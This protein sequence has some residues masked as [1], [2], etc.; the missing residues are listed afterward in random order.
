MRAGHLLRRRA[1]HRAQ[2]LAAGAAPAPRWPAPTWRREVTTA[3]AVH[4]P[5]RRASGGSRV[6]ALDLGIKANTPRMLAA[7][8][9]ETHVLPATAT[10][11]ELL[12]RRARRG[13]PLQRPG[14]PGHR[15]PRRG[16]DRARCCAAGC[17]C[18]ASAS[19]T[20]SS[21]ARSGFGTYKLPLRAPR[22]QRAGHRPHHRHGRDHRAEPRLRGRRAARRA[23]RLPARRRPPVSHVCPNDD[24]V[25]GL[26]L[27]STCRPSRCSTTPRRR[28]A[29]TTP[30]TCSTA[31][32]T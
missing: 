5:R 24:V 25:E 31:S 10:I 11:D 3:R 19:A 29:R 16:A 15:R 20:R 23:R 28:P 8:G 2:L 21:A 6:A 7:R 32:P 22:H 30:P 4:R 13:V 27:R 9:I 26:D 17:R 1:G 12:E 14:R 18:S